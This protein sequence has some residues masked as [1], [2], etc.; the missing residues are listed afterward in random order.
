[1]KPSYWWTD[2]NRCLHH[3]SVTLLSR[4]PVYFG[5]GISSRHIWILGRYLGCRL[6][7][8]WPEVKWWMSKIEQLDE[9]KPLM[10]VSAPLWWRHLTDDGRTNILSPS[11]SLRL[12][13]SLFCTPSHSILP[14]THSPAFS[15][16]CYLQR[17]INHKLWTELM[18][19]F[20]TADVQR[21]LDPEDETCR[22]LM[23]GAT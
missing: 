11:P 4:Q 1:M 18:L 5:G 12:S 14:Q 2:E 13:V 3:P 21:N 8:R 9:G 7:A 20:I 10:A 23:Y 16:Y 17:V 6:V 15:V 19:I 22:E